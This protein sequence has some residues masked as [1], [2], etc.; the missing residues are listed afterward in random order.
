MTAGSM[1]LI[2]IAQF[3]V[4]G[5]QFSGQLCFTEPAALG[6]RLLNTRI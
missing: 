1:A 6:I 3:I 4:R 5:A 2:G